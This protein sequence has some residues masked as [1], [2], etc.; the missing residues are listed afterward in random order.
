M[1]LALYAL[2][3]VSVSAL[4]QGL[5]PG[6]GT[7]AR[8]LGAEA[9]MSGRTVKNAPYSADVVTESTQILADGNRIHQS[10]T[11]KLYRD[12]EGRTRR[13]QSLNLNGLSPNAN[14][15]Q[16]IFI[17]DPVAGV[18]FALNAGDRTGTKS[19][20]KPRAEGDSKS[21][22]PRV[23]QPEQNLKLELLG[24]QTMEGLA[25]EGRRT[26]ITIPAGRMGNELPI[27]IVT[28]TWFSPDLQLAVLT[29]RSDP[30]NGETTTK[31]INLS[32]TEPA[33][34]LFEVPA[35]YKVTDAR[36]I[37]RPRIPSQTK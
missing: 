7:S 12:S 19:L 28:E 2:L 4:A 34:L 13:E 33:H 15:P 11:A 10:S 17:N 24:R 8:F 3:A 18:N 26:T 1:R 5:P 22:L 20:R 30:R 36:A 37:S 16:L 6:R 14:L 32:R 27:Q 35:D 31:L 21:A 9:G 29:K 23:G 25:V